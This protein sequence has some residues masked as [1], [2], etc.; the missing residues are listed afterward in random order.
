[1][2]H[3][4]NPFWIWSPSARHPPDVITVE[5]D[6]KILGHSDFINNYFVRATA[7]ATAKGGGV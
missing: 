5:R 4:G 1:M 6:D 2:S 3:L 7:G